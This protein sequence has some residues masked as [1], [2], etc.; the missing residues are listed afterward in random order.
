MGQERTWLNCL[1]AT[2][3]GDITTSGLVWSY[4]LQKH[5]LATPA[6]YN[7]LVFIADCGKTIHCVDAATGRA[8]WTHEM[9]GE[10]W[11]SPLVA[12]GKVFIGTRRGEFVIL[13]A[14]REKKLLATIDMGAPISSTPVAANGVLYV[15]TMNRL[16]AIQKAPAAAR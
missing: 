6:I 10:I 5:V 16:F 12:D 7:G 15:A 11:A 13:T 14:S 4:P 9:Q 3:T 2:R 1:D 8:C